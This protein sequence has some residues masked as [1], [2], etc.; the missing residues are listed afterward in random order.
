DQVGARVAHHRG[1]LLVAGAV[2]GG[3]ADGEPGIVEDDPAGVAVGIGDAGRDDPVLVEGVVVLEGGALGQGLPLDPPV[4][5][6]LVG[7]VGDPARVG[8]RGDLVG[9]VPAVGGDLAGG[10]GDGC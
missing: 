5:V 4:P 8:D 9:L 10:V 7:E 1:G 6:V 3:V 2:G